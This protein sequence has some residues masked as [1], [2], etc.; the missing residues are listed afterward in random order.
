MAD[1]K[2][3]LCNSVNEKS[4]DNYVHTRQREEEYQESKQKW[5]NSLKSMEMQKGNAGKSGKQATTLT[6]APKGKWNPKPQL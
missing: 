1:W 3:P 6:V 2:F 5:Q 4:Q